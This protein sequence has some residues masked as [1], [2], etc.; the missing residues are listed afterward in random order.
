[1]KTDSPASPA[2]KT[3]ALAAPALT[4]QLKPATNDDR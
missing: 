1:M 2:L 3:P 4:V